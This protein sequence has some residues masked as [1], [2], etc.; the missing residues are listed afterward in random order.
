MRLERSVLRRRITVRLRQRMEQ[1][2]VEEVQRLHRA[3][4]PYETF[5]L[6]GLEYRF[7]AK[8]LRG[9]LNKNDM[10]QKLNSAIHQLA[11]RQETWFRK[12]ERQGTVIH[13]FDG[14]GNPLAEVMKVLQG[15]KAT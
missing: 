4:V 9:E 1:G 8:Y 7:I 3:G 13:W 12:M 2:M 14:T 5:E 6:Y 11:K 10:F 15:E